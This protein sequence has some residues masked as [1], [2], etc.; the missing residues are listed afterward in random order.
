MRPKKISDVLWL[1]ANHKLSPDP[2]RAPEY[3]KAHFSCDAVMY[4]FGSNYGT[5]DPLFDRTM[6][7]LRELG[8]NTE[9]YDQFGEFEV[10]KS[11]WNE[12]TEKAQGARYLWLMF[13]YLVAR[14]E[15]K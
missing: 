2:E 7:F 12:S 8:V 4:V 5:D 15:R 11:Y 6:D 3:G 9:A 10:K 13:A 1:A 14:S